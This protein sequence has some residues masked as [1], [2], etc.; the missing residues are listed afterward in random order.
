MKQRMLLGLG[1][2]KGSGKDTI[3]DLLATSYGFVKV[4][5]ADSL[6]AGVKA[7]HGWNDRHVY[8]DL[9]EEIDHYWGYSP[10]E[11]L[12]RIGTDLMRDQWMK[13]FWIKSTMRTIQHHLDSYKPVVVP[14]CRFP[15]ECDAILRSGGLVYRVD[16]PSVEK[17]GHES[18]NALNTY[19]KWTGVIDNSGSLVD[20]YGSIEGFHEEFA[21][22]Y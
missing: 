7:F 1:Y 13:D 11:A 4:S 21:G 15:N 16:R 20:L 19:D 10:R 17:D 5:W 9:K 14:D 3:A 12:Q 6:K 22:Y 2:K 18:E 8:G